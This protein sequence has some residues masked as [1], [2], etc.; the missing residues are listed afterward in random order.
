MTDQIAQLR[1]FVKVVESGNFTRA[2]QA[3]NLPRSSVSSTIQALEDRLGVQLLYRT[4]HRVSPMQDGLALFE[5]ATAL[6]SEFDV[7]GEMFTSGLDLTGRIWFDLPSRLGRRYVIPALP[8][9]LQAHPKLEIE[10][11]TTD[12]E[13]AWCR[14][15]RR[16][17]IRRYGQSPR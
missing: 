8:S 14:R 2:A 4:T 13:T 6:I 1:A 7:L 11:S 16:R 12:D 9:F 15:F 3:L 5:R 10:I 17:T